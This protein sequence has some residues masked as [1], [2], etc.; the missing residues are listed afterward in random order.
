MS[1]NETTTAEDQA[2]V[3]SAR[4]KSGGMDGVGRPVDD[5]PPAARPKSG[6]MD[7]EGQAPSSGAE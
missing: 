2:R 7:G 1:T 5:A 3:P 6:G 4:P